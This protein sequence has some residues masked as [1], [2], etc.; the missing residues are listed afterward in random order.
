[1]KPHRVLFALFFLTSIAACGA[2]KSSRKPGHEATLTSQN[3]SLENNHGSTGTSHPGGPA[4]PSYFLDATLPINEIQ[5]KGTHNSYHVAPTQPVTPDLAYT[6]P[7]L[8]W[9]L[10]AGFRAF[11]LDLHYYG[12]AY[13][14]YHLPV[15][16][17]GTT[18]PR[19]QQCLGEIEAWSAAHPGHH[20]L[21]VYLE[22]KD[23]Y[24]NDKIVDHLGELDAEIHTAI[25][26]ERLLM[27]DDI[28]QGSADLA[29]AVAARGWP[30]LG[31]TRGKIMF[32]M[33]S[34]GDVPYAY[35]GEGQTLAGRAMFVASTYPGWRH[36]MILGMD[37]A[38]EQE[39]QIHSAVAGGYIVRTRADDLPGR[40][41]DF[42]ARQAA[43]LRGGA[44]SVL[45]DYPDPG[46]LPGYEMS[47]PGGAPSRCNPVTA[48]P[49]C[50]NLAVEN[51]ALLA[52]PR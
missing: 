8:T 44:Q 17:D 42:P 23:D 49:A 25:P 16:D 26:R 50:T 7:P 45:T 28:I 13:W 31:E 41:G 52:P 43:A 2:E 24:D 39:A 47:I 12:G 34:F 14:V 18:C 10:G 4:A 38:D 37:T 36:A 46:M 5:W 20:L 29:S 1:M 51:P 15:D 9:Q 48:R 3:P 19:F 27:P 22:F 33:W 11:E 6:M 40:G 35:T 32:V 30:K 21:T